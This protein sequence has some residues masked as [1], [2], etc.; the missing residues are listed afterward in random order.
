MMKE[1]IH[2]NR[3]TIIMRAG[4]GRLL[5]QIGLLQHRNSKVRKSLVEKRGAKGFG[6][7]RDV[8]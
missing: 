6:Y 2:R 1:I 8:R 5:F 4:P 3:K 7:R